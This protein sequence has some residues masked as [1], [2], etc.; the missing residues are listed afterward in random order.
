MGD[1]ALRIGIVGLGKMGVLHAGIV[2]ALSNARVVAICEKEGMIVRAARR[3]LP[4]ISFYE[5]VSE[6]IT[7]ESLDAIFITSPIGTHLPIIQ[8][9][10]EKQDKL[11]LFVEKPLAATHKEAL[12]I[13]KLA[14]GLRIVNMVGLQKRFS[15]VFQRGKQILE[16]EGIGEI[17][18]FRGYSYVSDVFRRGEGWRF[19]KGAGGALLDLGPHAI[20]ILLW[21]F[22]ELKPVS[23]IKRPFYSVEVEDYL[24]SILQTGSGI[25]GTLD[26]CWS[27]RNYRLPE[28]LV[29]VH[30]SDGSMTVTDDYVRL[31][32]DG[33]G[34][35][36]GPSVQL[37]Q[38]T[39]FNTSVEFL[40]ADPEFTIEDQRFLQAVETKS[41]AQPDFR[42]GAKI[43][44]V[45]DLI[46]E[47][48]ENR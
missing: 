27:I 10:L 43:N 11:G 1:L 19:K 16:E 20:D 42:A 23:A 18:F 38:K 9:I 33:S 12:E 29:E 35:K 17:Q 8:A 30:G 28:T 26:I 7:R 31:Q 24:H 46:Q 13:A 37:L 25:V 3:V 48:A 21:Y 40:L 39:A 44:E 15:P 5:N 45:I 4:K 6:M 36:A 2:N 34:T 41:H 14:S 32:T 22:G 47:E